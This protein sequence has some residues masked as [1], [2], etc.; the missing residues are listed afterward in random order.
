MPDAALAAP[1]VFGDESA[2]AYRVTLNDLQPKGDMVAA[3]KGLLK[4]KQQQ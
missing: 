2:S 3:M 1:K 4:H